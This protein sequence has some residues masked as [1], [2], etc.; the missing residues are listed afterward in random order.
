MQGRWIV[1]G[2]LWGILCVWWC[3][4]A[5]GKP[6][7]YVPNEGS[8][9]VSVI[10]TANNTV[11][12]N[13]PVALNPIRLAVT[14]DRKKV[15]VACHAADRVSVIATESNKVIK[16]IVVGD[17]PAEVLVTPSG[18][19]VYVPNAG[20]QQG[21]PG[22]ISVIN[23]ATDTVI[24]NLP[25]GFNCRAI[26]WVSNA[27]GNWVY[28][29]NQGQGTVTVVDDDTQRIEDTVP[30]GSGPRQLAVSPDNT[31]VYATNYQS[32]SVTVINAVTHNA[33][34][35][36][37]VGAG[38]RG[39]AVT[40]NG[41]EVW[42]ANLDT[43]FVSVITTSNNHVSATVPVGGGCWTVVINRAGTR[44][45]VV[46]SGDLKCYVIDTATKTVL[47]TIPVG[48]GAFWAR[49]NWPQTR[50]YVTNPPD[51][52][53]SV[54][55]IIN[56]VKITDIAT[57][58]DPWIIAIASNDPPALVSVS[59]TNITAGATVPMTL[60]GSN[61]LTG[62]TLTVWPSATGLSVSN[63]VVVHTNSITLNFTAATNATLGARGFIITNGDGQ[64]ATNTTL[65][66][67]T[68]AP[69]PPPAPTSAAPNQVTNGT[70]V[71][72]NVYG[73][74]FQTGATLAVTPTNPDIGLAG[75]TVVNATNISVTV[76]VA[77][78]SALGAHGFIVTNPDGKSGTN[79][80]LFTVIA[81]PLPPPVL[82]STVPDQ[83]TAGTMVAMNVFGAGFQSNA[84]L[85]V[86]PANLDIGLA[87]VAVVNATNITVTV[88]V[89][90]NSVTG[91][92][93]FI[94]TNPDTQSATNQTLYVIM[95][96]PLPAPTPVSAEPTNVTAG[97]TAPMN[98]YGTGFQTGAT[99]A[100]E[101][102]DAAVNLSDIVIVNATN[103]TLTVAA[104]TNAVLGAYGFIVTNPDTQSATNAALFT[105]EAPA[106]P[107]PPTLDSAMPDQVAVGASVPMTVT[108]SG[109]HTNATLVLEPASAEVTL[110]DI[111]IV[112]ATTAT[113]TVAASSNATTGAYGL[114][115][116]N[117]DG[118]SAT[119]AALFNIIAAAAPPPTLA[120]VLPDLVTLGTTVPMI[121]SGTGFQSNA[122]V[123]LTP[124]NV[125]VALS[126]LTVAGDTNITLT[127]AVGS[128]SVT[129]AH[130]FIVTNPDGQSVTNASLF[131]IIALPAIVQV[132]LVDG[133][134]FL[135][136]FTTAPNT[137][138]QVESVEEMGG[139]WSDVAG[140]QLI[141]G[142][143][144]T[145][146][147]FTDTTATVTTTQ[148]FY[149]VRRT[150]TP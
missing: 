32:D 121:V 107:P 30:V 38:P 17:V 14:P 116:T 122:T 50:L 47:T 8:D 134:G 81:A 143:A 106:A 68:G 74:G 26:A 23:T 96:A 129:G 25:A 69:E 62:A 3:A 137:T 148:R 48:F 104:G 139:A 85:A 97:A 94:V 92:H 98:V 114:I 78:N 87:D 83:V 54:L 118:Q 76:T 127:A 36:V 112:D 20:T 132:E 144:D 102:P 93:G 52:D 60:T 113:L 99:L 65:Y 77:T 16:T 51:D 135:V 101:P 19:R 91:A 117:P 12:T 15:Y 115:A 136:T 58:M 140:G 21:G 123:V 150:T 40:P 55:D 22:T 10:D 145:S 34:T 46:S 110:S 5:A 84:T 4:P 103:I 108:G 66:T 13:I 61:F 138:N 70:M 59:P 124:E 131:S 142:P 67:V 79:A 33:I 82:N 88:A 72:M 89:A 128:N 63:V 147:I 73:T 100:L 64:T 29:A 2:G 133:L 49:F 130:G 42:V 80:T 41:Q 18:N 119:N 109:L 43:N 7:A 24:T 56:N 105:I 45:Y 27:A 11:V 71:A 35:G 111:V 90:S 53:V 39:I 126:D 31:R 1:Y 125:E 86:S 44:A 149:R 120:A 141:A 9:T 75:T 6:F 57:G 28:V 146:L 37:P 95:P